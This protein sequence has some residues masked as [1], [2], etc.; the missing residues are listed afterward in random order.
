MK[1][2]LLLMVGWLVGIISVNATIYLVGNKVNGAQNW[3]PENPVTLQATGGYYTFTADGEFKLSTVKAGWDAGFNANGLKVNGWTGSGDVRTATITQNN[4][5]SNYAPAGWGE[6][7]YRIKEDLSTIEA[8]KTPFAASYTDFYLIGNFN[9][10]TLKDANYKF[11]T[12]DGHVYTLTVTS[13]L[14]NKANSSSDGGFKIND[15]SWDNLIFGKASS[16]PVLNTTYS[17][18]KGSNTKNMELGIPAGAKITFTYNAEGISTMLIEAAHTYELWMNW[19]N[20]QTVALNEGNSYTFSCDFAGTEAD[21]KAH[22][23]YDGNLRGASNA[24]EYDGTSKTYDMTTTS[25]GDIT[26]AAGLKGAV[27]FVLDVTNMKLTVS[28]GEVYVAP[29]TRYLSI[30]G[31]ANFF[32]ESE[33]IGAYNTTAT[34][35]KPIT[36]SSDTGEFFFWA[37][38][39]VYLSTAEITG[40]SVDEKK[41]QFEADGFKLSVTG[42]SGTITWDSFGSSTVG[43]ASSMRYVYVKFTGDKQATVMVQTFNFPWVYF[44]TG[45]P[46]SMTAKIIGKGTSAPYYWNQGGMAGKVANFRVINGTSDKTYS[47]MTNE[48]TVSATRQNLHSLTEGTANNLVFPNADGTYSFVLNMEDNEAT[49]VRI[50]PPTYE[51]MLYIN[52]SE[53]DLETEIVPGEELEMPLQA[54]DKI[55]IGYRLP[56]DEEEVDFTVY[57]PESNATIPTMSVQSYNLA[58]NNYALTVPTDGDYKI[59]LTAGIDAKPR[60]LRVTPPTGKLYIGGKFGG[61]TTT[62]TNPI[63]LEKDAKGVY[64]VETVEVNKDDEFR[65]YSSDKGSANTDHN[66]WIGPA[67]DYRIGGTISSELTSVAGQDKVYKFTSPGIYDIQVTSYFLGEVKFRVTKQAVA[68]TWPR[69]LYFRSNINNWGTPVAMKA[70]A[71]NAKIYTYEI[72]TPTVGQEINFHFREKQNNWDG[73]RVYPARP[74]DQADGDVVAIT[75]ERYSVIASTGNDDPLVAWKY[76]STSTDPIV[77]KVDF[78]DPG[79][80]YLY[81]TQEPDQISWPQAARYWLHARFN[82]NWN[83]NERVLFQPE[84]LSNPKVQT[85]TVIYREYQSGNQGFKITN[86]KTTDDGKFYTVV[87]PEGTTK[88]NKS[89]VYTLSSTLTPNTILAE[90]ALNQTV[91][92]TLTLNDDYTAKDLK[93]EWDANSAPAIGN[94]MPVYPRNV[95][96]NGDLRRYQ[97]WPVLYLCGRALNEETITP[98]YQMTK[99]SDDHYELIFPL[100]LKATNAGD[101]NQGEYGVYVKG[102]YDADSNAQ[103]FGGVSA[104]DVKKLLEGKAEENWWDGTRCRATCKR[105]DVTGNWELTLAVEGNINDI[106][107][108]GLIGKS[109]TQGSANNYATPDGKHTNDGWQEAWIQ[110]DSRSQVLK[111]RKGNVMYNTMWPPR[112]PIMFHSEFKVGD[113]TKDITLSSSDLTFG[114]VDTKSGKEWK[115]DPMFAEYEK[116]DLS[117]RQMAHVGKLA[118]DDNTQYTL[119]R[120]SDVWLNGRVKLWTGWAGITKGDVAVWSDHWNWGYWENNSK[121]SLK[122]E[123]GTTVPL[124]HFDA[125]IEYTDPTFNKYVDFFYDVADPHG[126]G[127]CVLF[128]E[129]AFGG[130][131]IFA[132]SSEGYSHGNFRPGL[133][134]LGNLQEGKIKSVVI[135]SYATI[136]DSQSEEPVGRVFTWNANGQDVSVLDFADLFEDCGVNDDYNIA[137]NK[138]VKTSEKSISRIAKDPLDY[139][140]GD[141]FYRMRVVIVD[142]EGVEHTVVVDSNVFTIIAPAKITLNAYQLVKIDDEEKNGVWTGHYWTYTTRLDDPTN[143]PVTPVYELWIENDDKFNQKMDDYLD[144]ETGLMV[145]GGY[146]DDSNYKFTYV[147]LDELPDYG[148]QD[149]QFTD[150]MLLVGSAPDVA[151]VEGYHYEMKDKD[152]P[153]AAN[154]PMRAPN[155]EYWDKSSMREDKENRFMFV[156]NVENFNS[157]QFTLTLGYKLTDENGELIDE[158]KSSEDAVAEY[159]AVI[160]TPVLKEA[161]IEVFYGG[162]ATPDDLD[163]D[164]KDF[165]YQGIPFTARYHNVRDRIEVYFPNASTFFTERIGIRDFFTLQLSNNKELT[166]DG[167]DPDDEGT[168]YWSNIYNMTSHDDVEGIEN[169][170]GKEIGGVFTG[171]FMS[172]LDFNSDRY[173]Q[174]LTKPG[175]QYYNRWEQGTLARLDVTDNPPIE[176]AHE[177]LPFTREDLAALDMA[178]GSDIE[179]SVG[180]TDV[181]Y[182]NK[183]GKFVSAVRIKIKHKADYIPHP[184]A[185]N[186]GDATDLEHDMHNYIFHVGKDD[187]QE[188]RHHGADDYYYVTI[189]NDNEHENHEGNA[190]GAVV[191][192]Y[193]AA[194]KP[195]LAGDKMH[196]VVPATQLLGTKA[197]G[198]GEGLTVTICKVLDKSKGE[199]SDKAF[200][201]YYYANHPTKDLKILVSYLYPFTD[202]VSAAVP[203]QNG[204]RRVVQNYQESVLKSS[205]AISSLPAAVQDDDYIV[206]ALD[207]ITADA[208]NYFTVGE[209]YIDVTGDNVTIYNT[210][211]IMVAQGAGRHNLVSGVYVV[212]FNGNSEKVVVK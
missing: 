32:G 101:W 190:E 85:A 17:L 111:D 166:P 34:W 33:V 142:N 149:I 192:Q 73:F 75:D 76:T 177:L 78:S 198:T 70:D 74:A 209:G 196:F 132:A 152:A 125:D 211:G 67:A 98:E 115:E 144:P 43:S 176:M 25:G 94:Q 103:E 154:G 117:N 135:N 112:Y 147:A 87:Y 99:I 28:G 104:A 109:W 133:N 169:E 134:A 143:T 10:W 65:F 14:K 186:M 29:V 157:R 92:L 57:G 9:N 86:K 158:V 106:P 23:L 174:L 27:K 200:S 97:D 164:V 121:E 172:P 170:A 183:D 72:P 159:A 127:H 150:K 179:A 205:A 131:E 63:L 167:A 49:S 119:Y 59:V 64:L 193:Y 110:Y 102:F 90:S 18:A 206:A 187:F 207:E 77:F 184:V 118:L 81:I 182:R 69:T 189:I 19:M 123:S 140:G 35:N 160:P 66:T 162:S 1:K 84:D 4:G 11:S 194:G 130:A 15:G 108:V 113:D 12:E 136:G 93:A 38:G 45:T 146:T 8:S 50:T 204:K 42:T 188:L 203:A 37:K 124:Y 80:P 83:S 156:T 16:N 71:N 22:L 107:Y 178:E 212:N 126:I 52:G 91:K 129:K 51:Y 26:F 61:R 105:N 165:T 56:N 138:A 95:Y 197:E 145:S 20:P 201:D 41:N 155:T 62:A 210:A 6:T 55:K 191:S 54:G 88:A 5:A 48:Q 139:T 128:T 171:K 122:V 208:S 36:R 82:D 163:D 53:N 58:T 30:V 46:G 24:S 40:G 3:T 199:M 168:R 47:A 148:A 96:N 60:T 173:M 116:G 181:L 100:R 114:K 141:Y 195:N 180:R 79:A 175:Y 13:E 21:A 89:Q 153:A 44:N 202:E 7:Y 31:N 39:T 161:K 120:V 137:G 185:T 2:L 151:Y 68:S